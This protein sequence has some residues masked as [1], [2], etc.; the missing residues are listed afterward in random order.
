MEESVGL[1]ECEVLPLLLGE[2][3]LGGSD[4]HEVSGVIDGS[5]GA[6]MNVRYRI[7]LSSEERAQLRALVQGGKGSVRRLK[8][9]QILLAAS[10][11]SGD[12][13]IAMNVCVGT[14][15]VYRTKRRFVEEGLEQALSEE[16]R[17]GAERKLAAK[18]EALLVATAC[19][20]P[21][22][23]RARWTLSLLADEMVR[24]TRHRSLSSE[25]IRR[26]LAEN[27][28]KPWQKKMW[29]I[30]KVDAE[31]VARMEDVLDLYAEAPDERRPVVCFDETPR[32]LIGE[33]R[34]PVAAKPGKPA[35][36]DYEY[37]RNGTANVFMFVDAH[38][39]W[40]HAK[41][42][43]RRTSRDFAECMRDLA[44]KHYP[45]AERIR[46]VMDNLSTHTPAALYETF[47]PAE[48]R[49][50]LRRLEFH[51]TPKHA[52]WL[53]MVEI[54]IGVM[55]SQCLDRRIPERSILVSEVAAWE[56]RRNRD[57]AAIKWLF[58]VE[59]AREKLGRAYPTF[60][61]RPAARSAE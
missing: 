1:D 37:V 27:E 34:V 55:V 26:R 3:G 49:R 60:D 18:E 46:M 15:T 43:D 47:E 30:P 44:D 8:R 52:S 36:V 39:P 14:S 28:L 29:C 20:K 38:R 51:Y 11:G 45:K 9:A 22:A 5:S 48:A 24:L 61:A 17:P 33:S 42:T 2:R 35:R 57:K 23:G 32:Q 59:R 4:R 41:V 54:E 50:V 19:S 21:P 58:T 16:P 6:I 40:R 56:R 10:A 25:T 12:E 13:R 31:F 53:N 7:T